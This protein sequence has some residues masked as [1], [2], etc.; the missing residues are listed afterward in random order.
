MVSR[1]IAGRL[2]SDLTWDASSNPAATSGQGGDRV[3]LYDASG[4]RVAQLSV[5]DLDAAMP[6]AAT[7][8]FG[9]TEATDPNTASG[10][11]DDVS[12]TRFYALGGSTVATATATMS[13]P[14]AWAL[15]FGD[16]QGSA[17]VSMELE[18]DTGEA[19]GFEPASELDHQVTRNAYQPYGSRRGPD[20]L[21]IDRGW[22]GQTED[23]D[24]GLTYLN[25]RYYDRILGR[26]P[27][28]DPLIN[29]GDPRTL[30]PYRYADNN[31]IT[32]TDATG[33]CSA[34]SGAG[35]NAL[36]QCGMASLYAD[37]RLKSVRNTARQ[38]QCLAVYSG[39]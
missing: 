37:N 33:L 15:L 12:A 24:T 23:T 10:S 5:G 1:V 26:F 34:L 19:S 8:Y 4:Q 32:F 17:Q 2:P 7:V 27:S 11:P 18:T 13:G 6:V 21:T 9:A 20:A 16:V 36:M 25:A 39:A 29:L 28:P 31:P 22:L 3:Y 14:V 35:T 30:D 38:A